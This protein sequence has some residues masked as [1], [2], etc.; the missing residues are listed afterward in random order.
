[1]SGEKEVRMPKTRRKTEATLRIGILPYLS[2]QLPQNEAP[3]IIPK[4]RMEQ[5]IFARREEEKQCHKMKK[6][7]GY[8][9]F[10]PEISEIWS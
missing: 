10:V 9:V 5:S 4:T 1:M 2:D 6:R 8:R 7:A 3:S